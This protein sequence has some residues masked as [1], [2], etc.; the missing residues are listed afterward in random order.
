MAH[1]HHH[2]LL[3]GQG[4][5]ILKG[6]TEGIT[7]AAREDSGEGRSVRAEED[8]VEA[9]SRTLI[10]IRAVMVE[11]NMDRLMRGTL[12]NHHRLNRLQILPRKNPNRMRR[13]LIPTRI[14]SGHPKTY[15]SR[16]LTS[17]RHLRR[18]Q[19]CHHPLE[20]LRPDLNLHPSLVSHLKH[21]SLPWQLPNPRY[22]LNLTHHHPDA[23]H[24]RRIM[25]GIEEAYRETCLRSRL[26]R[27]LVEVIIDINKRGINRTDTTNKRDLR[28]GINRR[29]IHRRDLNRTDHQQHLQREC[30]K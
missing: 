25:T 11:V 16:I 7:A 3:T 20:R 30:A 17:Q 2:T 14:P 27:D 26:L 8:I 10:G 4:L 5:N 19:R 13:R 9:D 28:R 22:L 1:R 21:L 15:R 12:H 24:S 29:G 18:P 23:R 6:H